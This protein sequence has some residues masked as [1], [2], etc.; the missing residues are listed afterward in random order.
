MKA[1]HVVKRLYELYR[2]AE[3]K[4]IEFSIKVKDRSI[5]LYLPVNPKDI[6]IEE[7]DDKKLLIIDLS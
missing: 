2:E 7:L 5:T 1:K 4:N 3:D 6:K